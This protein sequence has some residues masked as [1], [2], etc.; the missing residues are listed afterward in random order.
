[1]GHSRPVTGLLYLNLLEPYGPLQACNGTAL[2]FYFFLI[3]YDSC[4]DTI[5]R[6]EDTALNVK[7]IYCII[8]WNTF[9]SRRLWNIL[10]QIKGNFLGSFIKA[11]KIRLVVEPSQI[12]TRHISH[13][14]SFKPAGK[15]SDFKQQ[16]SCL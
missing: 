16:N 9:E 14:K 10:T 12:Q 15:L 6:S 11:K 7:L 3:I 5:G 8:N 4:N 2:L 1:M 13:V